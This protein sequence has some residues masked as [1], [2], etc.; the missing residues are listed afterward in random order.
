MVRALSLWVGWKLKQRTARTSPI[1]VSG[2]SESLV[3]P[4]SA[5]TNDSGQTRSIWV[6]G[7]VNIGQTY[8]G[9]RRVVKVVKIKKKKAKKDSEQ[10]RSSSV[11]DGDDGLNGQARDER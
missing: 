10:A 4:T 5:S 6:W 9:R 7:A 3:S 8:T 1:A 2:S 11:K